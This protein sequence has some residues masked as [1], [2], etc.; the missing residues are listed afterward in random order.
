MTELTGFE[1]LLLSLAVFRFTHLIV[2]DSITE[3]MRSPFIEITEEEQEGGEVYYYI[4]S[5]GTGIRKFVGD[6]LSCYWCT[7]IWASIIIF[8]GFIWLY[9]FMIFP[10]YLLAIAGVAAIVETILKAIKK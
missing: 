6:V 3:F 8:T 4:S 1:F 9:D 5:R 2:F 10:V 7:G